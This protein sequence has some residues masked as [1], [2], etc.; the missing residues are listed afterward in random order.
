MREYLKFEL[1]D[2]E[3]GGSQNGQKKQNISNVLTGLL[4]SFQII[5]VGAG[6]AFNVEEKDFLDTLY[7]V[8][9]RLFEHPFN[10]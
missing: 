10:Y 5:D 4:C 2:W 1:E 8:I 6:T 3:N 7:A 9:Q